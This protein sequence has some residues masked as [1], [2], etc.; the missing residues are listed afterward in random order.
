MF[1][2]NK[3]KAANRGLSSF[4]FVCVMAV[5]F[6]F[7]LKLSSHFSILATTKVIGKE[8]KEPSDRLWA[9]RI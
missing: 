2:V 3:R 5:S 9:E 7:Y 1:V 8:E 4:F 6:S